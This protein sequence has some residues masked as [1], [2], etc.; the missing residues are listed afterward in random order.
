MARVGTSSR[1]LARAPIAL[2]IAAA[3]TVGTCGAS[4]PTPVPA[5]RT[6]DEYAVAFCSAWAAMFRG[7]GN[8]DTAEGSALSD[9]LDDAMAVGDRLQAERLATQITDELESARRDAAFA[10]GWP[11]A[12]PMMIQM[13]RVLVGF[14][15][16]TDAK[17]AKA[18]GD[19][20][21]IEPQAA[22]EASGGIQAWGA[23][24]EAYRAIGAD[25]PAD[26]QPCPGL[27]VSP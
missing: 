5:A 20:N 7:V 6:F 18:R 9:A 25:R 8:P 14:E 15:A 3:I 4:S 1:A 24:F 26:V 13:D 22:L 19:P 23:M 27:P 12:T 11:P 17:V 16:M 10:G 2:L 21:A